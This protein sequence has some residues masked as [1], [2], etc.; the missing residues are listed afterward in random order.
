M[1]SIQGSTHTIRDVARIA[2][3]SPGTVSRVLNNSNLVSE[4]TR[5]RVLDVVKD[6]N[7]QPNIVARRL[8]IGKTLTIAA[9]V[10]FFTR[11]SAVERLNGIVSSLAESQ[12]DL[13]IHNVETPEHR[14][15]VFQEIPRRERVDGVIILSLSPRDE[16]VDLLTKADVPIV[17][18]DANHS[19]LESLNRVIVDDVAGGKMATSYLFSLGHTKIGF[20]GDFI[21]NPFNFTSSGDRYLGYLEAHQ[22]AG[23][24]VRKEY[25]RE[26]QH[27]RY[28]A[29]LLTRQL[30]DLPDPP[31]AVFA[32]SD[33]QAMGAVRAVRDAGLLVPQDFSIVGYDDIE[34]AEYMGLTTVRQ[35]LF[36]SGQRGVELLLERL[37]NPDME[38]VCEVLENELIVRSTTAFLAER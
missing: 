17:L 29:Y 21:D 20:V 22:D 7:Y 25:F 13:I 14:D 2:G 19:D 26:D 5:T 9:I 12:Y 6:L 36:E 32:A 3:V 33:T 34:I 15:L 30:L 10:P 35:M 31:T 1:K 4:A 28:A 38:P 24:Q 27:E 16:D 37:E 23:V 11:P 8:S 18:V